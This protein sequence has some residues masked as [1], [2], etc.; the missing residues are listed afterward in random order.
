MP[1][2]AITRPELIWPGKYDED[3]NRVENRGAALPFQVIET[4]RECRATRQPGRTMSLFNFM[5]KEDPDNWHN[6]LIW[7]DNLLVLASLLEEYAGKVDLIYIDPPFLKQEDFTIKVQLAEHTLEK[8]ASVIEE[9]AYRDTW[10]RNHSSYLEMLYD[11]LKLARELLSDKGSIFVHIGPDVAHYV[12]QI[13]EEI[14]GVNSF[15]N[16][17]I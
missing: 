9:K 1:D 16:E 2:I 4:I 7:G 12:R 3:G 14:F 10:G 11:R 5:A 8:S 13:L 6:K 17:V 15:L